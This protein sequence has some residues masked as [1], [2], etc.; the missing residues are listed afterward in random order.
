MREK[1][2]MA[3]FGHGICLHKSN[4]RCIITSYAYY[5]NGKEEN[6][7]SRRILKFAALLCALVLALTGCNLVQIDEE[8]DSAEVIAT[9]NGGTVTKGEVMPSYESSKEYYEY[10]SSYYGYT[11]ATDGL[12]EGVV[13]DIVQEK[14]LLVKAAELG[15]DVLTEE[16]EAEVK[17]ESAD[18][19]EETVQN[20]WASFAQDG[21]TDEEIRADIDEYFTQNGYTLEALEQDHHDHKV[22]EKLQEYVYAEVIVTPEDVQNAYDEKVAADEQSYSASAY[23]YENAAMD[24]D[25]VIAWNPEGYRTV[26]HILLCFTQ[27]EQ[28]ELQAIDTEIADLEASMAEL[29]GTEENASPSEAEGAEQVVTNADL[30]AQ[31]EKQIEEKKAEKAALVAKFTAKMQTKIDEIY[32]RIAAGEDFN[33][34]IEEY[35]EDDGMENEPMKTNGYYVSEASESWVESFKAGALALENIGDVSE[36]IASNYGVHIFR[37]NGDVTPG[38]VPF[39]ELSEEIEASV[40]E[41][42]HAQAYEEY[43]EI[44]MQEADVKIDLSSIEQ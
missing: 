38:A 32:A 15:L 30:K 4:K 3:H 26:K 7:M 17:Q 18:E 1:G 37:Y 27:D 13:D 29:D 5:P 8:M 23:T 10:L 24:A 21:M 19:Y 6:N 22:I 36:P 12:L 41:E 25:T 11:F 44:W 9:F 40:T 2:Q 31:L 20:Y 39:D 43:V 16:E 35:N 33:A 14:V 34:L 28:S 42:M